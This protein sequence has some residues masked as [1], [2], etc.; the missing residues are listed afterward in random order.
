MVSWR[1]FL[2]N[3]P[4]KVVR[5]RGM[6]KAE[7]GRADQPTSRRADQPTSRR[8]DQPTSRRADEP[9]SRR[10]DEPTSRRADE[11]TSRRS[12][13]RTSLRKRRMMLRIWQCA[14]RQ[15]VGAAAI[16]GQDDG[17][18]EGGSIDSLTLATG[19]CSTR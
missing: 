19:G 18:P 13:V 9:T 14:A 6:V 1:T 8:A 15:L 7:G 11:P 12:A 5:A 3:E 17:A 4:G 10:A 2:Q 16:R